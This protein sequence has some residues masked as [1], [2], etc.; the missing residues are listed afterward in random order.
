MPRSRSRS[1]SPRYVGRSPVTGSKE[2][3]LFFDNR[4]SPRIGN[5]G[6]H[7][8]RRTPTQ[9]NGYGSERVTAMS[10]IGST[11]AFCSCFGT[12]RLEVA[13]YLHLQQSEADQSQRRA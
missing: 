11:N 10:L 1:R 5:G 13:R 6:V 8:Q 2:I 7:V 9:H 3:D 4:P 12:V